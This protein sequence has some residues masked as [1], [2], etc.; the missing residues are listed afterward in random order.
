VEC[1]G[2]VEEDLLDG[3]EV[4][5]AEFVNGDVVGGP[6]LRALPSF[7]LCPANIPKASHSRRSRERG[8]SDVATTSAGILKWSFSRGES[9][10]DSGPMVR[11]RA[12]IWTCEATHDQDGI[13]RGRRLRID[14]AACIKRPAVWLFERHRKMPSA[15]AA[16]SHLG[17]CGEGDQSEA[18]GAGGGT[19]NRFS[20]LHGPASPENSA[21]RCRQG[22]HFAPCEA[23]AFNLATISVIPRRSNRTL[24]SRRNRRLPGYYRSPATNFSQHLAKIE[25]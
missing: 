11:Q 24:M 13:Q 22:F 15:F 5:A 8:G 14:A 12:P 23:A 1:D 19:A 4:G 2:A 18:A 25:G 6:W 7:Q 21:G 16:D 9:C 17:D 10:V 20:D 3:I